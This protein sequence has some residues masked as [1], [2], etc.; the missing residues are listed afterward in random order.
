MG[1]DITSG[2]YQAFSKADLLWAIYSYFSWNTPDFSTDGA[3]NALGVLAEV[4]TRNVPDNKIV[5]QSAQCGFTWSEKTYTSLGL[6]PPELYVVRQAFLY[7]DSKPLRSVLMD[8]IMWE[9]IFKAG[10]F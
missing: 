5:K 8:F 2:I 3:F 6:G 10:K 4:A 1:E 7:G 9:K